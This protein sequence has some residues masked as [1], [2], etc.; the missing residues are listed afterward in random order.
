MNNQTL[1]ICCLGYNHAKFL[2]ENLKSISKISYN[3]IQVIVVDDGSSDDSTNILHKLAQDF[4]FPITII[5]Q[6]NTGN[7]GK[8]F[9]TALNYASGELVSFIALDDVFNSKAMLTEI[10]LMN[11]DPKLAFV[12][13]ET[14]ISINDEGML[15]DDLPPLPIRNMVKVSIDEL[16]EFEYTQFGSFYIQG[17]IF[18]KSIIDAIGGFDEDMTGD[19]IILRVKLFRYLKQHSEWNYSF[20][21]ENNVFYR[22]HDNNIHKN[23]SR[24]IRIV[25]EYL[26]RYWPDKPNPRTLIDW[27]KWNIQDKKIEEA[28]LLFSMNRRSAMLLAEPEIIQIL[29]KNL[30]QENKYWGNKFNKIIKKYFYRKE[31]LAPDTRKL[32]LFGIISIRYRKKNQIAPSKP[33]IHYSEYQ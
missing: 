18:R 19:D 15:I 21:D 27:A 4:P 16:L 32:I 11:E 30:E 7:I 24:Q 8:N 6:E 3:N 13:A 17:C 25:T 12:A 5:S 10:Q 22:L 9:N 23:G 29:K 14:A 26:D 2:H 33:S 31:K 20:I 28:A 1:S